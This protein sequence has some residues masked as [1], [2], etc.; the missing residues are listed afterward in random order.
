M[1]KWWI[2]RFINQAVL[3]SAMGTKFTTLFQTDI[4]FTTKPLVVVTCLTD[5][6][7]PFGKSVYGTL[8]RH[9]EHAEH[10]HST[11]P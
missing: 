11:Q 7:F 6:D 5:H 1:V 3:A 9:S 10:C 8:I 4:S 2:V